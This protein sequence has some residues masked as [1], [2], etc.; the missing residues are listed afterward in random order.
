MS[1]IRAMKRRRAAA[2]GRVYR[3]SKKRRKKGIAQ[4]PALVLTNGGPGAIAHLGELKDTDTLVKN[5]AD[6]YGT[7]RY[8]K[9]LSG[10]TLLCVCIVKQR[11]RVETP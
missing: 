1:A 3:G 11:A 2:V 7:G 5:C 8:G 4:R 9:S 6:C 10:V